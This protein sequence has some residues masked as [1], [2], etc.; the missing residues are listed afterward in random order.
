MKNVQQRLAFLDRRIQVVT[1]PKLL[2]ELKSERAELF[3]STPEGKAKILADL[4]RINQALRIG[5][6]QEPELD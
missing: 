4:G 1:D 2:E 5:S 6:N 3:F